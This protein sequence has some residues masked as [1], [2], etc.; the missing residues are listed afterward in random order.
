MFRAKAWDA[1]DERLRVGVA[2]VGQNRFGVA[3]FH[4]LTTKHHGHTV[5][6]ASD[7]AEIVRDEDE[8]HRELGAEAAK[9]G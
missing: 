5:A 9:L 1:G 7:N 2:G 8:R 4:D 3:G 6:E